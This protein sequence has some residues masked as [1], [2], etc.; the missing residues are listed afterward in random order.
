MCAW[1]GALYVFSI[2]VPLSPRHV[3]TLAAVQSVGSL[4]SVG[5]LDVASRRVPSRAVE[6]R[7][8]RACAADRRAVFRLGPVVGMRNVLV[9]LEERLERLAISTRREFTVGSCVSWRV[10][11][12]FAGRV[13]LFRHLCVLVIDRS[14]RE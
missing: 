7:W 4:K 5:T 3:T 11:E 9:T 6:S 10:S 1:L 2:S 12:V 8:K 13:S 14:S